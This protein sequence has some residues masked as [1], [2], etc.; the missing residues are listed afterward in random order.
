MKWIL[1]L[2]KSQIAPS[3]KLFI[4]SFPR[5][6]H[7]ACVGFLNKVSDFA[8]HYCEFYTCTKQNG[9]SIECEYSNLQ[10]TKKKLGCAAGNRYLKNHDFDLNLP[11]H[12]DC[13][14]IVQYRHPF[15]SILSWYEM[16]TGKGKDLPCWADFFKEKLEF[17][18]QFIDKWVVKFGFNENVELVPY[19][20]M[21]DLGRLIELAKFAG[22]ELK[23]NIENIKHNFNPKRSLDETD[24]YI[25]SEK[26]I[27]PTLKKADISPLFINPT[28]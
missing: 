3:T 16:E 20:S 4:V 28:K 15:L 22:A 5:S 17:W 18:L 6:G 13:K 9:A 19:D 21:A 2:G 27:L 1:N 26:A 14:Y 24:F 7:H 23:P 8:N 11:F 10:Y 12:K 25:E